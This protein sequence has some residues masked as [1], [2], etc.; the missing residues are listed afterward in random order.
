MIRSILG[1][2]PDSDGDWVA[3]LS[4][5]HTQHLRHR[6]PFQQRPWVL[7]PAGRASRVG[8]DI[9]C[10]LCDRAELPDGLMILGR[11]G[12][13][14]QGSV[15]DALRHAHLTPE[16]WWGLLVVHDG[17]IGFQ[18]KPDETPT[19][20]VVHLD[21]GAYQSIPPGV[22]HRLMVTGP[23]EVELQFRGRQP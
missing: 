3:E 10:P 21:A 6:P 2:H 8:S 12:P 16:G 13:W 1:F 18:F 14:D 19:A 20:P 15:P 9:D 4:C 7:D 17:G 11:A 23:V 22:P 5:Y